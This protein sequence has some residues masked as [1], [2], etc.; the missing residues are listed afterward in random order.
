MQSSEADAS[1]MRSSGAVEGSLPKSS[2]TAALQEI[3]FQA[4]NA[5]H[6]WT[7][8]PLGAANVAQLQGILR[9]RSVFAFAKAPLRS[10]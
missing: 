4:L 9:L 3:L 10:G 2:A 8:A 7:E 1:R 5:Y 6:N